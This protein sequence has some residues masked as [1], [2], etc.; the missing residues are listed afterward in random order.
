MPPFIG[1]PMQP[2]SPPSRAAW[3]EIKWKLIYRGIA[4]SPPS[5]A[6]WIEIVVYNFK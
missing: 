4:G 5:R 3:I 1:Q 2:T 6:A